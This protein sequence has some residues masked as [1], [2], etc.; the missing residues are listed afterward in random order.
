VKGFSRA[1]LTALLWPFFPE[2]GELAPH[3]AAGALAVENAGRGV[4]VQS[5]FIG[6]TD[7]ATE[8]L[9]R[10]TALRM[11]VECFEIGQG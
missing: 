8:N 11:Q 6:H 1:L 4:D 9:F 2:V 7:R 5:A 3:A 10:V